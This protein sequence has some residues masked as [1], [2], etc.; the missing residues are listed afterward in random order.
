MQRNIIPDA[1]CLIVLEKIDCLHIL[2]DLYD[3]ILITSTV[4]E[5]FGAPI[6]EWIRVHQV[7]NK[8]YRMLIEATVD[9]GEASVIAL[10]LEQGGLLVLDDIKAR[11]LAA[12]YKLEYT[13]TLGGYCWKP[14]AVE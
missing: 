2:H 11:K 13:G 6:P 4:A 10:A 12:Q 8:Q 1:S 5:E 7:Q 14:N 9:S 3:H